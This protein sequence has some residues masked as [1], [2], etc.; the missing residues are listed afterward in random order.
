MHIITE[1]ILKRIN[2]KFIL[3][4]ILEN[5]SNVLHYIIILFLYNKR[6]WVFNLGC[7]Y[8]KNHLIYKNN[9]I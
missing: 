6:P 9:Y 4:R 3:Y 5:R 8:K 2:S 1:N 7:K